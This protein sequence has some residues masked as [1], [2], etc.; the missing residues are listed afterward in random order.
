MRPVFGCVWVPA[1]ESY[2]NISPTAPWIQTI[3][4][5]G[6]STHFNLPLLASPTPRPRLSM[7]L[8]GR[9]L[10]DAVVHGGLY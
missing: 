7:R 3:H 5:K 8:A 4:G 2:G 10:E 6:T 1:G 9:R